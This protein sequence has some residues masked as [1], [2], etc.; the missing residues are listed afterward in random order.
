M[1]HVFGPRHHTPTCRSPCCCGRPR[2]GG[3]DRYASR[4][5][6]PA[7]GNRSRDPGA[8]DRTGGAIVHTAYCNRRSDTSSYSAVQ[9]GGAAYR[10]RARNHVQ[11]VVP[12]PSPL[13]EGR[14]FGVLSPGTWRV[15]GN[16]TKRALILAGSAGEAYCCVKRSRRGYSSST[17]KRCGA[18][19]SRIART[20]L[21]ALPRERSAQARYRVKVSAQDW[22]YTKSRK[23][24]RGS[25]SRGSYSRACCC[26][27]K[28]RSDHTPCGTRTRG[29]P[30]L[31]RLHFDVR[32]NRLVED[33]RWL[34]LGQ[35][36]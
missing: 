7:R 8:T 21:L 10:G 32:I 6:M 13:T 27:A 29:S 17:A 20:H 35:R 24:P 31:V 30:H 3:S 25:R 34:R 18:P 5:P 16:A 23:K 15:S 14:N 26:W 33:Q 22:Q 28:I 2:F 11:I 19:I 9:E 36:T 12:D 1:R 4:E